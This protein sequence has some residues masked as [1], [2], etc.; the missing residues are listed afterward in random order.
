LKQSHPQSTE[1]TTEQPRIDEVSTVPYD[2]VQNDIGVRFAVVRAVGIVSA[3]VYGSGET[4]E[5]AIKDFNL[6]AFTRRQ[7][8]E[9]HEPTLDERA[10]RELA[11]LRGGA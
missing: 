8:L 1:Q 4:R 2:L 9:D 11:Y 5:A 6:S 3:D 10:R 7:E